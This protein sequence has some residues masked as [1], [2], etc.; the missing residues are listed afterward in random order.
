[1]TL[2]RSYSTES[3]TCLLSI[4]TITKEVKVEE[5]GTAKLSLT[6]RQRRAQLSNACDHCHRL[7]CKCEAPFPYRNGKRCG[8]ECIERKRKL[9]VRPITT[10]YSIPTTILNL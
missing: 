4:S 2:N 3:A 8:I 6:Q 7:K 1:N 5:S 9:K 10:S